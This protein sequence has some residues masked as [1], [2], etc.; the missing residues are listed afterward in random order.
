MDLLL[1]LKKMGLLEKD[2]ASVEKEIDKSGKRMEEFLIEDMKISEDEIFKIKSQQLNLPLVRVNP[3]D[4]LSELLNLV[5]EITALVYKFIPISQDGEIIKIGMVYPEDI[6]T[7][8]ALNF[9]S[10]QKKFDYEIFLITPSNFSELVKKYK[11]FAKTVNVAVKE[12]EEEFQEKKP[13]TEIKEKIWATE[14]APVSKVLTVILKQAVE[15]GASD[16]HIEP[17]REKL[18]VRFRRMGQLEETIFLPMKMHAGIIARIKIISDLKIDESRI[19]QSGRFSIKFENKNIDFRASTFP[20]VLGEK[21]AIRILNPETGLKKL[22]NLGL[23]GKNYEIIKRALKLPFGAIFI[24]GPT[25]SGKSTTLYALLQMFD[26]TRKN[27]VTLEDPAE[28]TI[29]GINQSQIRPEI[30]YTFAEGLRSI[31]RQDPNVIMVGEVRDEETANLAIHAALTGHIVLSTLHTNTAVEAISRLLDLKVPY[32]LIPPSLK[33]VVAQR[34]VKMLC[35]FCKNKIKPK[36][37]FEEIILKELNAPSL[38]EEKKK[39]DLKNIEI[40]EAVGCDKC[41][42][43]GFIDR[44][45]LFE[46]LEITKKIAS[47]I[48]A[49]FSISEIEKEAEKMGMITMKQDGILKVLNGITTIEEVLRVTEE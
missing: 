2:I 37:E 40:Y 20:T 5:P 18:R 26:K 36:K 13:G 17:G 34:L 47:L 35:P 22:E 16:V 33:V 30:G 3:K 25:G 21:A 14:E 8:E 43:E 49:D 46:V 11:T 42:Q 48:N 45:A 28:Y 1:E 10:R 7:Q 44:V 9:L 38:F 23:T 32:F 29:E 24:T 12:F 39:F 6:K 19:P 4:L 41:N 15:G 27:I 31:L